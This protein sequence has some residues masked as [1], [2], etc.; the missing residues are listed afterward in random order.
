[1]ACSSERPA[2]CLDS[3]LDAL[4]GNATLADDLP[5]DKQAALYFAESLSLCRF[6]YKVATYFTGKE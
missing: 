5:V 4:A 2:F 1:M 6:K 3:L